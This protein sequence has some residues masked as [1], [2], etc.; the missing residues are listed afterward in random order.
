M[1]QK[2]YA[3]GAEVKRVTY[4]SPHRKQSFSVPILE[5]GEPKIKKIKGD[6][7]WVGGKPVYID[8]MFNFQPLIESP[9]KG[10]LCTFQVRFI[11]DKDGVPQPEDP[12]VYEVLERLADDPGTKIEREEKYAERTNPEAYQAQKIAREQKAKIDELNEVLAEKDSAIEE[13]KKREAELNAKLNSQLSQ[14]KKG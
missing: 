13:M 8:E 4:Y 1:A 10:F 12:R 2:K 14:P 9:V 5:N 6:E 11:A 7:V 3:P